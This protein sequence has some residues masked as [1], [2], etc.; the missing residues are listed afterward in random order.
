MELP[1]GAGGDTENDGR[2]FAKTL[3]GRNILRRYKGIG[4]RGGG[5]E[6]LAVGAGRNMRFRGYRYVQGDVTYY[7]GGV[8]VREHGSGVGI[9]LAQIWGEFPTLGREAL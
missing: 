2:C 8:G 6:P 7:Q 5:G 4:E 3:G 9:G 1:Y